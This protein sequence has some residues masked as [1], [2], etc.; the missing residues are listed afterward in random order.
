MLLR[1]IRFR[2]TCLYALTLAVIL[3]ASGYGLNAYLSRNQLGHVDERLLLIAADVSTFSS[4]LHENLTASTPCERL[5]AYLRQRNW[6]EYVQILNERGSIACSSSNLLDFS[7]PLSKTAL[8]HAERGIPHFETLEKLDHHPIRLLTYP[9]EPGNRNST[10]VQIG[11]SLATIDHEIA[12]LRLTFFLLGP[13]VLLI[14]SLGAWLLAGKALKPVARITRAV[15]RINAE[16]LSERLPVANN[17][18]EISELTA[19]FNQMLD[20]LENAFRRIK[21]FSGDASHELR[22]PLTILRGE[23]EV[24]LRWAK[25]PEEF[26][27]ALASNMEEISRMGRIIED[28]LTL[29]KSE[30]GDLPLIPTEFSFSDL[31]QEL[32]LQ[33]RALAEPKQIGVNLQLQVAEEIMLR[34][35]E[36]RLRQMFLNLLGNAIKYTPSG[37]RIDIAVT[38]DRGFA[39]LSITD[40][41]VGI[42]TEHLPHIFDRFYRID[43]ARNRE[44]GGTGLGLSIVKW[45]VDVHHGRI[46]VRSTPGKG[47]TFTVILPLAGPEA[48][49]KVSPS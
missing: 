46:E 11:Y 38:M 47:S 14:T 19:T 42:P 34:G 37:G 36:L 18:D 40:T 13:A 32:Y 49:K 31:I 7:L 15:R 6:G 28:L 10:M 26:R 12:D 9:I 4:I 39:I 3:T 25:E 8:Q 44:D 33:G 48:V 2:L 17:Q 24:A 29:A 5:E 41:G 35:D 21:Q 1:S 30:S 27:K 23:T 16:N 22:T 20:D 45:I 43:E